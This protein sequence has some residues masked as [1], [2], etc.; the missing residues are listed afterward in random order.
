M[1]A[2]PSQVVQVRQPLCCSL[3]PCRL[4]GV[5]HCTALYGLY[6]RTVVYSTRSSYVRVH[7]WCH[8]SRT[9]ALAR[10]HTLAW[11]WHERAC[12]PSTYAQR[13][14]GGCD[15][16]GPV[17]V[18]PRRVGVGCRAPRRHEPDRGIRRM[19]T[20]AR[21]YVRRG[22]FATAPCRRIT[23]FSH[24]HVLHVTDRIESIDIP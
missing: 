6:V 24:S 7:A 12:Q 17:V 23:L 10:T 5:L 11:P 22:R 14:P 9:C 2:S 4:T 1:H 20:Q 16:Q 18:P 3:Q 15:G 8:G 13:R 19:A 21:A